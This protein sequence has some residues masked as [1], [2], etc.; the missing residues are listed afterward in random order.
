MML[1]GQI[2]SS[3]NSILVANINPH[4]SWCTAAARCSFR[5]V[6]RISH[7]ECTEIAVVSLTL[8]AIKHSARHLLATPPYLV[9][10]FRLCA[11]IHC[12]RGE[13]HS[14]SHSWVING[15]VQ[16]TIH[17]NMTA[18]NKRL[19]S[20]SI[21]HNT[22]YDFADEIHSP[23]HHDFLFLLEHDIFVCQYLYCT[24]PAT[25]PFHPPRTFHVNS[26]VS[27]WLRQIW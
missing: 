1:H 7:A 27:A 17:E 8:G 26:C 9:A 19:Y 15:V 2:F 12:P 25:I 20:V 4:W 6:S 24:V 11:A 22:A 23:L 14:R 18:S 3:K 16:F 13:L 10:P 5:A 21:M